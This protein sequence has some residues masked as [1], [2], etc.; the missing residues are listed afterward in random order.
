MIDSLYSI[1]SSG[2]P[3]VKQVAAKEAVKPTEPEKE[4][5][6]SAVTPPSVNQDTY[7]STKDKESVNAVDGTYTSDTKLIEQLKAEQ[8]TIQ[9]R[10]FSTVK[11]ILSKQGKEIAVGEGIWKQLASGDFEVD[12]ETQAE[13][14][15]NISEDGYWGVKLTSQR[16]VNF[17]KALVGGDPD[18][19]DLMKDAFIKG[20]DAAA[21]TWGSVLPDITKDTYDSVMELFDQWKQESQP[22]EET[23]PE[24]VEKPPVQEIVEKPVAETLLEG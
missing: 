10:F 7:E 24:T 1:M 19:I 20:Y 21:E 4:G 14:Q 13:A 6:P 9:T 11:D 15:K 18:K 3:E 5:I 8:A 22:K 12:A 17:A 16:I 23:A 2:M